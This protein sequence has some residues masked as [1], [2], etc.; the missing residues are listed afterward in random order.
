MVR[1]SRIGSWLFSG[2][3]AFSRRR[4]APP[5]RGQMNA[6]SAQRSL[7]LE[8]LE[9]KRLLTTIY[10]EQELGSAAQFS[11]AAD[12]LDIVTEAPVTQGHSVIVEF[13]LKPDV[14]DFTQDQ[15]T[16]SI[17]PAGSSVS[18]PL[19]RDAFE[20]N[21][22][23]GGGQGGA[24]ATAIFSAHGVPALPAGSLITINFPTTDAQ[25]A[26]AAEFYGLTAVDTVDQV[27]GKES[28]SAGLDGK[29]PDSGLTGLT[30]QPHELLIGAVG[31]RGQLDPDAPTTDDGL[32]FDAGAGYTALEA[33]GTPSGNAGNKNSAI[34]AEYQIVHEIGQYLADGILTASA[35]GEWATLIA[36]YRADPT[37]HFRIEADP[38]PVGAGQYFD[39]IVTALDDDENVST[40]YTGTITFG[41]DGQF[42]QGEVLPA[43]YTF[44]PDDKGVH[45]FELGGRLIS[46]GLRSIFVDSVRE[47]PTIRQSEGTVLVTA[48]PP[49]ELQFGVQ[50]TN[51]PF[52]FTITPAVTV[53]LVD[54][55]GNVAD[56]SSANISLAIGNNPVAGTLSGTTTVGTSFGVATFGDL[57]INNEGLGYTLVASSSELADVTSDPFDITPQNLPPTANAGGPYQV[58]EGGSVQ[59]DAS[60]STDPDLPGEVLTYEWDFDWDGDPQNFDVDATGSTPTA[61]SF[62]AAGLDGPS[63]RTIGLRVSDDGGL[64]DTDSAQVTI[65]NVP[66]TVTAANDPVTVNE[67]AEATNTGTYGDVGDDTVT[68]AASVGTITPGAGTWSWSYTPADGPDTQTVTITATDSDNAETTTTFQL[69]VNNVAPIVDAG[70]DQTVDVGDVVT[71]SGS[72]TDPG[73]DTHTYEWDFGDGGTNDT[74]LT[75]THVYES[76]ATYTVTLTVTD[77]DGDV[78]TDTLTV[79][80]LRAEAVLEDPDNVSPWEWQTV[81]S[82]PITITLRM[83][84]DDG[85]NLSGQQA[86][87]KDVHLE[88]FNGL[89][90][91]PVVT[92]S[93]ADANDADNTLDFTFEVQQLEPI[94]VS[95]GTYQVRFRFGGDSRYAP[96]TQLGSLTVIEESPVF[97][98]TQ[99]TS[100]TNPVT[101]DW[102]W[103]VPFN[104]EITITAD[105]LDNDS[106]PELLLHQGDTPKVV[107]LEY[108]DG[109][110][111]IVA[112]SD[113]L[114]E[115]GNVDKRVEYT[116]DVLT[117]DDMPDVFGNDPAGRNWPIRFRFDGDD[118]Y[119]P[120]T[121]QASL[122]ITEPVPVLQIIDDGDPGFQVSQGEFYH[123]TRDSTYY[124]WDYH[125]QEA[126]TGLNQVQWVFWPVA[127]GNYRVSA[128]W[129]P[130]I[131]AATNAPFTVTSGTHEM[132]VRMNQT[133]WP[134]AYPNW[135]EAEGAYWADLS[136]SFPVDEHGTLTVTLTDNANNWLLA[137]AIRIEPVDAAPEIRMFDDETSL[138]LTDGDSTIDFGSTDTG[139]AVSHDFTVQ[140]I[141]S[142]NL[143]LHGGALTLPS[144][145]TDDLPDADIVLGPMETTSFTVTLTA[146]AAG[147]FDGQ[148]SLPNTDGDGDEN[149]FNFTLTGT[150]TDIPPEPDVWV[151]D[152][153]DPGFSATGAYATNG[154][155][156]SS[157]YYED[158]THYTLAGQFGTATY[159][160]NDLTVGNI[161]RVGATW[162][163]APNRTTAA[164]YQVAGVSGGPTTVLVNQQL[165]PDTQPSLGTFTADGGTWAV[166]GE[167]QASA[168]T[169]TVTLSGVTSGATIADAVRIDESAGQPEVDVTVDGQSSPSGQ[170]V[171]FGTVWVDTPNVTESITVANTGLNTLNIS[172]LITPVAPGIT[173]TN[174]FG[175]SGSLAP[176][177]SFTM[178]VT[179]DV[180]LGTGLSVGSH[181]WQITFN[182]DDNDEPLYTI[183]IEVD[184]TNYGIVDDDNDLN[185]NSF[186]Q[187]SGGQFQYYDPNQPNADLYYGDDVHFHKRAAGDPV[188]T[189]EWR[190]DGLNPG[191]Y[192]VLLTWVPGANRATNV[193]VSIF[194]G[195]GASLATPITVD[196][197]QSPADY[198][199]D[200][201]LWE[202]IF[203]NVNVT[204]EGGGTGS[205]VVRMTDDADDYVIADAIMPEYV[206]PPGS[207]LRASEHNSST[208][209]PELSPSD[210]EAAVAEATS[211]WQ[212]TGLSANEQ[213]RLSNVN[214]HV[215]DLATNVLGWAKQDG[216]TVYIDTNAAGYGWEYE[217][218]SATGDPG[219]FA[220]SSQLWTPSSP[221][222]MDLLTV[223]AHELGHVLGR[224][225]LDPVAHSRDVMAGSLAVGQ[226]RLP[227]SSLAT[228]SLPGQA[229]SFSAFDRSV[230][231]GLPPLLTEL[232]PDE[233]AGIHHSAHR[234][235][236]AH[237]TNLT[238]E[239]NA[240]AVF[241]RLDEFDSTEGDFSDAREDRRRARSS[242]GT[243]TEVEHLWMGLRHLFD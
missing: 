31:V 159:T 114:N 32:G 223:L 154:N 37:T 239:S 144:G 210:L 73:V 50:P 112:G 16:G 231:Q 184:V 38:S 115:P 141:G 183:P 46:T 39:I 85:D 123:L 71:F 191:V 211:L 161:Y 155:V 34:H 131:E 156:V 138:E 208:D 3:R 212:S 228:D 67:G 233:A 20:I 79:S 58:P 182:S 113:V 33:N 202:L 166:L 129:A 122:I 214:V 215:A 80:V 160:F 15:L 110:N 35:G 188:S 221:P 62:S 91:V 70:P 171:D 14:K 89:S 190:L 83:R 180:A 54:Q 140:N 153:G 94:D 18:I 128:T 41:F 148:L 53:E 44:T 6:A 236:D 81:Y 117:W 201:A 170:A 4:E 238:R 175:S 7:L 75:P 242:E 11:S 47:D 9:E 111:W 177:Q 74:T 226:S 134:A 125:Y 55:F 64:S 133:L 235:Y 197:E 24:V 124:D 143:T 163:G 65:N 240:D 78:G 178:D 72:F 164:P 120:V 130:A 216:S 99:G 167:F 97:Q 217:V 181:Q 13:A 137:D 172:N 28:F 234:G 48:G 146:A 26:T 93:L 8:P 22:A 165:Q 136:P 225:D 68:L 106:T 87:P 142:A 174:P 192:D 229:W 149:P 121:Q 189:V 59:L 77:S 103:T 5:T 186:R 12:H 23:P 108:Y 227:A 27:S 185:D 42:V 19:Q 21:L 30:S 243:D 82:D 96:L 2:R 1:K 203:D 84:E 29:L 220:S 139:T 127:A 95:V 237:V 102:S 157:L 213:A 162:F 49:V 119:A 152:N 92:D 151:I 195:L 173:V 218:Q 158:D 116:I 105:L 51:T 45:E 230:P 76:V 205:I 150:V 132:T 107:H 52:D 61:V 88:F 90:W 86:E 36:T 200:G 169:M 69:I 60:N 104:L 193:P 63:T 204:D 196:Q 232:Q 57:S 176:G 209:A 126:G 66:P 168:E 241:A 222:R 25:A 145:Y 147:T 43:D 135:F 187:V 10:F 198:N 56:R 194:D 206:G 199:I 101:G 224:H 98:D 118:R 207:A 179:L 17:Q 219:P 109:A 100:E 40:G